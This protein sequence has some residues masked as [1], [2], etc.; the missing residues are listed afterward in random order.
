MVVLTFS[1]G[2]AKDREKLY[3]E[4]QIW[5]IHNKRFFIQ[6]GKPGNVFQTKSQVNVIKFDTSW[7]SIFWGEEFCKSYWKTD[8][9]VRRAKERG[10]C[11]SFATSI[12]SKFQFDQCAWNSIK[13]FLLSTWNIT[14]ARYVIF[15][16]IVVIGLYA[17]CS[18]RG[19]STWLNW[20]HCINRLCK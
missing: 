6:T 19:T 7:L 20:Y 17:F 4:K 10:W 14:V 11:I 18:F 8:A 5:A 15:N 9:R 3:I 13:L 1:C 2:F 12:N 16:P